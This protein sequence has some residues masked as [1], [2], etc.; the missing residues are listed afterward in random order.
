MTSP[1]NDNA[2]DNN[3]DDDILELL[4]KPKVF[5]SANPKWKLDEGSDRFYRIKIPLNIEGEID[6]RINK[7]LFLT[8]TAKDNNLNLIL[9][10]KGQ[11]IERIGYKPNQTHTNL[12]HPKLPKLLKLKQFAMCE[13]R[14]YQWKYSKAMLGVKNDGAE[15]LELNPDSIEEAIKYFLTINMIKGELSIPPKLPPKQGELFS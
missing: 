3:F 4:S 12:N 10:Y 11:N 13:S 6:N 9:V 14:Y 8:G 2:S 1:A 15:E 5:V 7:F